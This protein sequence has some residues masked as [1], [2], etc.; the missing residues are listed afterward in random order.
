[1]QTAFLGPPAPLPKAQG[2]V[3]INQAAKSTRAL[4]SSGL[5]R[6]VVRGSNLK[7]QVGSG[8]RVFS[9][10]RP[11]H[12]FAALPA[13]QF[14]VVAW[15]PG[16]EDV[17]KR[18]TEGG[19]EQDVDLYVDPALIEIGPRIGGG[20]FG[21][22][23]LARQLA[24]S[25]MQSRGI[26]QQLDASAPAD[27]SPRS[28]ADLEAW[29]DEVPGARPMIMKKMLDTPASRTFA[30]AELAANAKLVRL[31]SP[32]VA[33]FLGS[34]A[35]P[36][37]DLCMLFD[38]EGLATLQRAF[39]DRNAVT[40][41]GPMLGTAGRLATMRGALR[42]LLRGVGTLHAAGVVHRDIK[43]ANILLGRDGHLKLIDLG[44]AVDVSRFVAEHGAGSPAASP[45]SP[46]S[47]GGEEERWAGCSLAPK[48]PY[49]CPNKRALEEAALGDGAPRTR[50]DALA[51]CLR[52]SGDR[53]YT[54]PEAWVDMRHPY[55]FDVYAVGVI[56]LQ[57]SVPGLMEN[58]AMVEAMRCLRRCGYDAERWAAGPVPGE[59]LPEGSLPFLRALREEAGGAAWD[60]LR[61]LLTRDPAL[62][63]S[64]PD[65]LAHPWLAGP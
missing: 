13:F 47:A 31:G 17:Y 34:Y 35:A 57:L 32:H 54:C 36:G 42:E 9:G 10:Q 18:A 25:E 2:H 38:F 12:A 62:R 11:Q 28:E 6:R 48:C 53:R 1:M 22:V 21:E 64:A 19:D 43:P 26:R 39:A 46:P 15:Q 41:L 5:P 51:A 49:E 3:C 20:G 44:A 40:L 45:S 29:L 27:T 4:S 63:I 59:G 65:A 8:L 50:R 55:A 60:L 16:R 33:R 30:E 37:G 23:F 14:S 58:S 7:R 61:G 56:A 52:G 24:V